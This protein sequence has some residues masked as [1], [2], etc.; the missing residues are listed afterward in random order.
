MSLLNPAQVK[1]QINI[2]LQQ[3]MNTY[4][5][6][7][8]D[9]DPAY[10]RL[11]QSM[12]QLLMVGGKRIRPYL[13]Y[14]AYQTFADQELDDIM[15]VAAAQEVLHFALLVHDDIID[16]DI[17]RYGQDNITGT[18]ATIYKNARQDT[19]H[20]ANGAALLAGDLTISLAYQLISQTRFPADQKLAAITQLGQ[21][22]FEVAGGQ[23]LDMEGT[24]PDFEPTDYFKI[25]HYKTASY[26][27]IGPLVIGAILASADKQ[28]IQHLTDFGHNLG[29]AFQL[30]DDLLGVYG[31]AETTGKPI[32]SDLREGK[33]T[34]FF[35]LIQQLAKPQDQ[36]YF[37]Q[38]WGNPNVT[39][40]DVE[41]VRQIGDSS[42]A[43]SQTEALIQSYATQATNSLNQLSLSTDQQQ[44][45]LA[46][47]DKC[48]NRDK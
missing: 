17:T 11:W 28:S 29:V 45:F 24:I 40:S 1:D 27:F 5:H 30:A 26:S 9:I 36:A 2:I 6:Q 33:K 22:I 4:R 44:P 37:A 47:V 10:A 12:E 32:T 16:R 31:N 43:K 46:L 39:L 41:K 7:A 15:Q 18:Y 19:N 25:A 13:T 20:Y 35:A 3:H 14:L 8:A 48:T 38:V 34:H 21:T 23:L 42:T